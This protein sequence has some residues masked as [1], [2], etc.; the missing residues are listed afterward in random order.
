MKP[1]A[2]LGALTCLLLTAALLTGCRTSNEVPDD[3]VWSSAAQTATPRG[4]MEVSSLELEVYRLHIG[5]RYRFAGYAGDDHPAEVTV[6]EIG[7]AH[8]RDYTT[9]RV[10]VQPSVFTFRVY[11]DSG[12]FAAGVQ[13]SISFALDST[14]GDSGTPH[15]RSV[16]LG[17]RFSNPYGASGSEL[18]DAATQLMNT[19][20]PAA[21]WSTEFNRPGYT[22]GPFLFMGSEGETGDDPSAQI[23]FRAGDGSTLEVAAECYLRDIVLVDGVGSLTLTRIGQSS[24]V[25]ADPDL[26]GVAS[27]D[28]TAEFTPAAK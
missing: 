6:T 7:E 14:H 11:A 10:A 27:G 18:I 15:A 17:I 21:V 20:W 3:Y 12:N 26:V 23:V 25:L 28:V 2:V 24:D 5:Q 16:D 9:L 13:N 22:D 1:T 19:R 4:S 8:G